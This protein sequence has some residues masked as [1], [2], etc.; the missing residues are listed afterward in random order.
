MCKYN[1]ISFIVDQNL[2]NVQFEL[3][4]APVLLPDIYSAIIHYPLWQIQ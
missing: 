3:M 2:I 1:N 4:V